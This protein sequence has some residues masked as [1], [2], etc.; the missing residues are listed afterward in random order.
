MDQRW[1]EL[2]HLY[3]ELAEGVTRS[4]RHRLHLI[5]SEVLDIV[6]VLCKVFDDRGGQGSTRLV[7]VA[8]CQL[9][10]SLL[11]DVLIL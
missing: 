4:R 3:Y 5:D 7:E 8:E 1:V 11:P 10:Q 2:D 6:A 9:F